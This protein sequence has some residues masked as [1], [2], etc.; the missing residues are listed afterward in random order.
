[1]KYKLSHS[2]VNHWIVISTIHSEKGH[3]NVYDS[4]CDSVDDTIENFVQ[5][6]SIKVQMSEVQKQCGCDDFCLIPISNAVQLA[7]KWSTKS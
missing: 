1:M 7:K 4:L 5:D 3:I 2:H 6:E